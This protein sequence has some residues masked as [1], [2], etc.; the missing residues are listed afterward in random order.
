MPDASEFISTEEA[1]RRLGISQRR[2]RVLCETGRFP[3]A[4]RVGRDWIINPAE[5]K[6]V[7]NRKPGRPPK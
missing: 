7:E 4:R 1:A 6:L 2:V 3:T 5:L